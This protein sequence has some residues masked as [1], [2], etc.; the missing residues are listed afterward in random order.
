MICSRLHWEYGISIALVLSIWK[1]VSGAQ[2]EISPRTLF[3]QQNLNTVDE[4]YDASIRKEIEANPDI[5]NDVLLANVVS[6]LETARRVTIAPLQTENSTITVRS[7]TIP[8]PVATPVP[9]AKNIILPEPAFNE[10]L[11]ER[12]VSSYVMGALMPLTTRGANSL[13][14]AQWTLSFLCQLSLL[15][16]DFSLLPNTFITYRIQNSDNF[17]TNATRQALVLQQ[18]DVFMIIGPNTDDSGLPVNYLFGPSMVPLISG[19]IATTSLS[20]STRFPSFFRTI[21]SDYAV[22]LA[23]VQ[24]FLLFNWNWIGTIYVNNAA[25]TSGR[26][27]LSIATEQYEIVVKCSIFFNRDS[28]S[29]IWEF[30][31]CIEVN[32]IG[33]VVIWGKFS[34]TNCIHNHSSHRR[35]DECHQH[36]I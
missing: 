22:A 33:V 29:A 10:I 18:N 17:A 21:P 4:A 35:C 23:M 32:K 8:E 28:V 2:T 14:G 30:A 13:V 7:F 34:F 15:N 1:N 11:V 26:Q 25:G 6:T 9:E 24:T 20:N 27:A 5:F 16:N 31:N 12:N 19:N 36:H 3:H